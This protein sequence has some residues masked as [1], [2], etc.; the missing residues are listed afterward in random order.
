[1]TRS[2]SERPRSLLL[3]L[4]GAIQTLAWVLS[5]PVQVPSRVRGGPV[6]IRHVLCFTVFRTHPGP[7]VGAIPARPGP[8]LLPSVLT[9]SGLDGQKQTSWPLPSL[10][11]GSNEG[12]GN[13]ADPHLKSETPSLREGAGK[14]LPRQ[15]SRKVS[16]IVFDWGF[17]RGWFPK[18]WF[19]RMLPSTKTRNEGT[20]GCTPEPK[21]RTRVHSP[22]PHFYETTLRLLF[23][24]DLT[25]SENLTFF[26]EC[27]KHLYPPHG[28]NQNHGFGFRF[29][30]PFCCLFA[31]KSGVSFGRKWF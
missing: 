29:Q 5:W 14:V 21:M 1:M 7:E 18:G 10:A 20:C 24:L 25:L 27:K 17:G 4:G 31:R 16:K 22:K 6:Q 8:I 9:G 19:W 2:L 13:P 15:M 28:Q 11:D 12:I 3:S 30:F 23:P 26:R